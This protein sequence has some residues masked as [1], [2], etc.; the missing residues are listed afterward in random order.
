MS[1]WDLV[2][3]YIDD[4][5]ARLRKNYPFKTGLRKKKLWAINQEKH[6]EKELK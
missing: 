4:K 6:L 2:F 5:D 3:K 1:D